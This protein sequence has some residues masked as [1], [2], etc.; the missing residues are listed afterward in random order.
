MITSNAETA[1][2]KCTARCI[3]IAARHACKPVYSLTSHAKNCSGE[4]F[5]KGV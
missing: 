4:E 3:L 5:I 2:C 1:D